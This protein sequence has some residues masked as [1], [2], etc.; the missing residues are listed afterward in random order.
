MNQIHS[1]VTLLTICIFCL[2]VTPLYGYC[3]NRSFNSWNIEDGLSTN[4]IFAITQDKTGFIWIGTG[5]GL[6]RFDGKEFRVFKPKLKPPVNEVQY[7][8]NCLQA[9][10]NNTLWV[11]TDFNLLAYDIKNS[12]FK[13][14]RFEGLDFP[15]YVHCLF[16]DAEN[17]IWAGTGKGLFFLQNTD[18]LYFKKFKVA[19]SNNIL[20]RTINSIFID[21]KKFIWVGTNDGLVKINNSNINKPYVYYKHDLQ[22]ENSISSN[23]IS[24]ITADTY[25]NIWV[26]TQNEGIN[27][28]NHITETFSR[29]NTNSKTISLSNNFVRKIV[30]DKQGNIWVGTQEGLTF[31]NWQKKISTNFV[32]K[33][34]DTH[35]LSQNSIHSIYIDKNDLVW[36]GTF[37]GGIN[38][39]NPF[40]TKF[41]SWQNDGSATGLSNNV[42]SSIVSDTK[43]N[44]WVATEGG[45]ISY[46]NKKSGKFMYYKYGSNSIGTNLIKTIFRDK[47][48]NIWIGTH[49]GGLNVYNNG[50]FKKYL[51]K[52][53]SPAFFNSEI[54]TI[55]ED[56][57]NNLWLGIQGGIKEVIIYK[58]NGT[59]LT[60]I[61]KEYNRKLV[62][63]ID[64]K[65][66]FPDSRNNI[67]I[68]TSNGLFIIKN[69]TKTID[70][71]NHF[72][73]VKNQKNLSITCIQEDRQGNMWFGLEKGKLK[74]YNSTSHK[75]FSYNLNSKGNENS[76]YGILEDERGYIWVSTESGLIKLN[77]STGD[78][79]RYTKVDGLP[80]NTFNYNA[81]F[82]DE[83]GVFY[84]GGFKG[85]ISFNPLSFYDNNINAPIEFTGLKTLN[86]SGISAIDPNSKLQ[87]KYN[88]NIFT[89]EFA[90]LNY[91]K[92]EKN[93]YAYKLKGFD[94][95]WIETETPSVTYMNLPEKKYTFLVKGSN[96]DGKWTQIKELHIE[97]LPP[98]WRTW[99]AYLLYFLLTSSVLF[100]IIRFFYLQALFRKENALHQNK[101]DFFTNITHEIRTHLTLILLPVDK[102]I[103]NIA[104]D[105]YLQQQLQNIKRNANNLIRLSEE[106]MD[107]RKAETENLALQVAPNDIVAFVK[108]IYEHFIDTSLSRNIH[109]SFT[110][111]IQR[112]ILYFDS[113]QLEK[114]FFNLINNA[115]KFTPDGGKIQV[116]ISEIKSQIEISI[117]DNGV[118]I[119]PEYK[120]K[121]FNNFFQINDSDSQNKGYGI[122][123]ALSNKIITLHSGKIKVD[124]T[125]NSENSQERKTTFSVFLRKGYEHFTQKNIIAKPKVTISNS[126]IKDKQL[127]EDNIIDILAADAHL[128]KRKCTVL[129]VDDNP[130]IRNNLQDMLTGTYTVI[131]KNDGLEGWLCAT[132]QLPDLIVSDVMMPNE[133]GFQFCNRIKS[134]ARTCHIPVILLTAKSTQ[135]DHIEGL[136]IGADI[137]LTK[138]FSS[139][140]LKLNIRNLLAT[141]E[142]IKEN[143]RRI[144]Q[145]ELPAGNNNSISI[146]TTNP[147]DNEFLKNVIHIIEEYLDDAEFNVSVLSQKV[148][149]SPPV[150]YKK[151][152]AISNLTVNEFIK[153]VKLQKA[154]DML[155]QN[156]MA[157]YE[158]CYA[159]GFQDKK[160]FSREFKKKY[161]YTPKQYA[162]LHQK[163][164]I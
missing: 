25:G 105:S 61:S 164:T 126:E 42:V 142:R 127:I 9:D 14:A 88:Q 118:G 135:Q 81:Y 83:D 161:Q 121:L 12:Q 129:V 73:N 44:L 24:A 85:L 43:G 79:N 116:H 77:P 149:M 65:K 80:S 50:V 123:L 3:Q 36:V 122:G 48:G 96:N 145:H 76:L 150:L 2:I 4:N 156:T 111:N 53:E 17:K 1:K 153:S 34:S 160:Y 141:S 113:E 140:I 29:I 124:S 119:A 67:W 62:K 78:F 15:V 98:I 68:G 117:I 74:K 84:F 6:N 100:F 107:F 143:I 38:L 28:Y 134:D 41:N 148:A 59:N 144:I 109:I 63:G 106:L 37:F 18:N 137:Y 64:T 49:G 139:E 104:K 8:I 157:V 101:L 16:L 125:S 35:S 132:E 95:Q 163:E 146:E 46:Y 66:I 56:K 86:Q 133:N 82:K 57:Y 54:S 31:L 138:P 33:P 51:Y 108:S 87:L 52:P 30:P 128:T 55:A 94:D 130:E 40:P 89:I 152:K 110:H 32:H 10:S 162:L 136:N 22:D 5:D 27:L 13:E 112:Q 102:M 114:V 75:V 71:A 131:L 60:E 99:W 103:S 19:Q 147:L 155:K 158:V 91:I 45:G 120:D 26:G 23:T 154:A 69:G 7:S 92:P 72:V 20:N 58:K 93:R 90:I 39:I 115:F 11:G 159:I 21:K 70:S 47:N 151:I 97:V